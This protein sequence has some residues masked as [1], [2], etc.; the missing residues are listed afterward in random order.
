MLGGVGGAE[1]IKTH[2][3]CLSAS[4]AFG[5]FHIY[6]I[7]FWMGHILI[8]CQLNLT[9]NKP[10]FTSTWCS[11]AGAPSTHSFTIPVRRNVAFIKWKSKAKRP[12]SSLRGIRSE[13]SQ[14][15]RRRNP[16]DRKMTQL[17][18]M[19][20]GVWWVSVCPVL[21][22]L[23]LFHFRCFQGTT[24]Q[25]KNDKNL[26]FTS[27]KETRTWVFILFSEVW[28]GV[29]SCQINTVKIWSSFLM[30]LCEFISIIDAWLWPTG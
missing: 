7:I 28:N 17:L 5:L 29:C 10:L 26:L 9:L 20:K 23:F 21:F 18:C 11:L 13:T 3:L 8:A 25:V 1:R 4:A 30:C 14:L 15:G 16:V 19:C 24:D 22:D 12:R 6:S 27:K 2:A